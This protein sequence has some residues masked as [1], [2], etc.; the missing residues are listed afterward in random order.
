LAAGLDGID[1]AAL[2][3]DLRALLD[4]I[5]TSSRGE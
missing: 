1:V 5:K 3:R 2:R 4:A